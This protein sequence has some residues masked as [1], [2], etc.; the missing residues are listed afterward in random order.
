MR[1]S[2]SAGNQ[3][4]NDGKKLTPKGEYYIKSNF[5]LRSYFPYKSNYP[6]VMKLMRTRD[7]TWFQ[8]NITLPAM[9]TIQK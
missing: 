8:D 6:I 1:V 3:K 9:P 5:H 4:Q 2:V 7:N